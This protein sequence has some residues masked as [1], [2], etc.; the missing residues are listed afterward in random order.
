MFTSRWQ[1]TAAAGVLT[2]LA[3]E[4]DIDGV[5]DDGTL[6]DSTTTF[7]LTDAPF[8]YYRVARVDIYV[9]RIDVS[10]AADTGTLRDSAGS[11]FITAATPRRRVN[12]LELQHGTV[13]TLG[14]TTLPAADYRS[15]ALIINA[16]SSS[17]TLKDGRVLT[18]TSSPGIDWQVP[19]DSARVTMWALVSEPLDVADTGG[20][21]VVDFDVGRNFVPIADL[22]ST[23]ADEGFL[24]FNVVR[25]VKLERSATVIGM[26]VDSNGV[27]I[28]DAAVTAFLPF[29]AQLPENTWTEMATARTG[30]DGRF[31]VAYLTPTDYYDANTP[32]H[33]RYIIGIDGAAGSGIGTAR[34]FDIA[35]AAGELRDIGTLVV[36]RF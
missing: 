36:P 31:T 29:D 7:L 15:L 21:I 16:D 8:P 25:A 22:D 27:A 1:V 9:E 2:L 30:T 20:T 19:A 28:V 26:A 35:L 33:R 4:G 6:P 23:S 5:T 14:G 34:Y 11:G 13:D 10:A 12:V 24:S 17:L 3:C 18:R 32:H